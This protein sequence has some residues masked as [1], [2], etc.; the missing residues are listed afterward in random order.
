[1]ALICKEIGLND[2]VLLS[3]GE[4]RNKG[5]DNPSILA[6]SFEALVGALYLDQGFTAVSAFLDRVLIPSVVEL[7]KLN[8]LKDPKSNFQEI[9]QDKT[10]TTPHYEVISESGPDHQKSYL[11]A[12]YIGEKLIA[13]GKGNSKQR[14]Q[15][16]AALKAI[17][18]LK[19]E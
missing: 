7:S 5:R 14:A 11:I 9:A 17:K 12:A 3:K 8:T 2:F 1:M 16:D 15:E 19:K 6:D 13:K 18:I 4:E 10:N